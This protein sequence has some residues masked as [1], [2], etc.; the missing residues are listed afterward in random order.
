MVV[1][2]CSFVGSILWVFRFAKCVYVPVL[3]SLWDDCTARD[4]S[5]LALQ[6]S[7]AGTLQMLSRLYFVLLDLPY[8]VF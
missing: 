2:F 6:S 7:V 4:L 1:L 3:N 8:T 5:L